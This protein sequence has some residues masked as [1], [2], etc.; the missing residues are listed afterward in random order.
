MLILFS[1]SSMFGDLQELELHY[2]L[3]DDTV[4]VLQKVPHNSGRDAIP[5]FLRRYVCLSVR[6]TG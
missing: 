1:P 5:M 2:F 6:H 4:E 3:A